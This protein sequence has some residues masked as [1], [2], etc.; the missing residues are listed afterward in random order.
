MRIPPKTKVKV[1]AKDKTIVFENFAIMLKCNK[2]W[3]WENEGLTAYQISNR[4]NY[5][6]KVR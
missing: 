3:K 1:L 6:L 2:L 4:G 5:A